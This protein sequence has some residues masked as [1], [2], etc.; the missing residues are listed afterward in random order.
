MDDLVRPDGIE[1]LHHCHR[2]PV[3]CLGCI[4]MDRDQKNGDRTADRTTL[5]S[6][7]PPHGSTPI[8]LVKMV[9]PYRFAV[10]HWS[11]SL[12]LI[13]IILT[14]R[15][16]SVMIHRKASPHMVWGSIKVL[17]GDFRIRSAAGG[18]A[19]PVGGRVRELEVPGA[20]HF[21]TLANHPCSSFGPIN[22]P[23]RRYGPT[24]IS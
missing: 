19:Y 5:H 20:I 4:W 7:L 2:P 12:Q 15:V 8:W 24:L 21:T 10:S 23:E 13:V 9:T 22:R 6:S 18:R 17:A 11:A 16:D 1:V 14:A 3:R